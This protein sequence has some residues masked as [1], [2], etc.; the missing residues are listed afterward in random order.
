MQKHVE[1]YLQNQEQEEKRKKIRS[2]T[3]QELSQR[4]K[5][6]IKFKNG[7]ILAWIYTSNG[8]KELENEVNAIKNAFVISN[9]EPKKYE[10]ILGIV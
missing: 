9:K 8:E 1:Q 2:T 7:D 5:Q 10:H 4:K 6:V 3:Q